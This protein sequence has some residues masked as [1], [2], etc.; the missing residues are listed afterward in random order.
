MEETLKI[1]WTTRKLPAKI[2]TNKKKIGSIHKNFN[3]FLSRKTAHRLQH[4]IAFPTKSKSRVKNM[5][6]ASSRS[7]R[8]K[9]LNFCF[10]FSLDAWAMLSIETSSAVEIH[11]E[12]IEKSW[13]H[14]QLGSA[15]SAVYREN[16]LHV[17]WQRESC[18]VNE[19]SSLLV[20]LKVVSHWGSSKCVCFERTVPPLCC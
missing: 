11:S 14:E 3:D 13:A 4:F 16:E 1:W 5:K 10:L 17:A 18:H 7:N 20:F 19:E 6:T 9:T 2:Q 15:R 8:N 12:I